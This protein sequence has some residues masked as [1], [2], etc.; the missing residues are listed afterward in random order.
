[1]RKKEKEEEQFIYFPYFSPKCTCG[2]GVMLKLYISQLESWLDGA[3]EIED[4][5][6]IRQQLIPFRDS[7]AIL[8]MQKT[9][10]KEPKV[11]VQCCFL[12]LPQRLFITFLFPLK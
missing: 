8:I 6:S 9:A 3:S 11:R 1:M 7:T 2:N 10:L 12:F 4:S 5:T